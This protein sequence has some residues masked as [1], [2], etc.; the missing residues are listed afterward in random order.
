M[1]AVGS[2]SSSREFSLMLVRTQ[3]VVGRA[4][5]NSIYVHQV[6]NEQFK[7]AFK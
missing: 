4:H 3:C 2:A 6:G 7:L 1:F 5:R